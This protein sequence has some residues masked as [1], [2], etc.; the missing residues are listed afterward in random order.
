MHRIL[1]A[2]WV[3]KYPHVSSSPVPGSKQD[4]LESNSQF[5]ELYPNALKLLSGWDCD[6]C[7]VEDVPVPNHLPR[8]FFKIKIIIL[9]FNVILKCSCLFLV[10]KINWRWHIPLSFT[11]ICLTS[12]MSKR[13]DEIKPW[14]FHMSF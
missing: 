2:S 14:H 11:V 12:I 4:H 13:K 1:S 5:W 9:K 10:F 6:H 3:G 7:P 8:G